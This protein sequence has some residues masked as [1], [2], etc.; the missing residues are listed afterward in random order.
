MEWGAFDLHSRVAIIP[1]GHAFR[2]LTP[3]G[4]NGAT[5]TAKYGVVALDILGKDVFADGMNE[6]GLSV[7]LF[8]HPGF[9]EY[10]A[11]DPAEANNTI[12]AVDV[13]AYILTQFATVDEAKIAMALI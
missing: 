9:A 6:A 13:V 12:T 10:P 2:G 1:R 3:E 7:G 11:Y 5:W 4:H 8:Y